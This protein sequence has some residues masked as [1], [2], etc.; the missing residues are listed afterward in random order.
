MDG[1]MGGFRIILNL[2]LKVIGST[3]FVYVVLYF[4]PGSLKMRVVE[5]E[6]QVQIMRGK[7]TVETARTGR[8]LYAGDGIRVTR[9]KAA[10]VYQTTGHKDTVK[11]VK[12][13]EFSV[14]N[15]SQ[16]FGTYLAW[17]GGAIQGEMGYYRGEPVVERLAGSI[18]RT[19]LL[20]G[21]SLAISL[22][23]ALSMALYTTKRGSNPLVQNTISLANLISGVHIIVLS[24]VAIIAGWAIPNTGFSIWLLLVLAVGNGTLMDYFAVLR[25][26]IN[27]A[28]QQDYVAAAMGRG[29]NPLHHA[30]IFE[31]ALS[32]VE[33]TSSRI[34][35]LVGGTIIIEWVFSYL[36]LG[37]DIVK[38]IQDRSFELIMGVTTAV[39]VL[40]ILVTEVTGFLRHKFDPRLVY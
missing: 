32:I 7:G 36:G 27:R 13:K 9:G 34:P 26:Q 22:I 29:A 10:L 31:I 30:A 37:Y 8:E 21:G 14:G 17:L 39:A 40:L 5:V 25:E 15:P 6:G 28:I 24:Y 2:L 18:P 23:L 4:T 16:L 38:A 19:L 1:K 3:F 20:V 12:G 35:A 33:A 11:V